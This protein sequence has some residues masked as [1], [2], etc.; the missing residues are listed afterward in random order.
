MWVRWLLMAESRPDTMAGPL[1]RAWWL[2]LE[3]YTRHP[4][5]YRLWELRRP[6]LWDVLLWDLLMGSMW[7][8]MRLSARHHVVMNSVIGS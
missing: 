3:L 8:S 4:A 7:P 2:A 1:P 6:E 5:H